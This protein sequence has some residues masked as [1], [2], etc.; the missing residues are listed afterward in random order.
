MTEGYD[1]IVVGAGVMGAATAMALADSGASVLLVERFRIGHT[2]GSSH[3]RSRIFRFSY[4][5]EMYVEMAQEA[6]GLWRRAEERSSSALLDITGGFDIGDGI[7][8]NA[9]A[10]AACNASHSLASGRELKA[11]FPFL[12]FDDDVPVLFSPDSGTIAADQ[13]LATFV[14]LAGEAGADVVENVRVDG[15]ESRSD[16]VDVIAGGATYRA[17]TVVVTSGAWVRPLLAS[18]DIEIPVWVTRET[19]AYFPLEAKPPT[20]VDWG[21]PVVYALFSHDRL[22][23]AGRHIAGPEVDPDEPGAP[24]EGSI[25]IVKDWVASHYPDVGDVMHSETCLYTN[26]DDQRFILERHGNIVVGSP[27]SGHGFKF[28]PLIG[29][30]LAEMAGE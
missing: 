1:H 5:E 4:P 6:L 13:A 19:V 30:R 25:E 23:K 12:R 8:E 11:R 15:L 24:D 22:L 3:G 10:L 20:L 16:G 26:T 18:I 9:R 27:C 14:G 29:E 7:E 21:D 28:A 17:S 2:H